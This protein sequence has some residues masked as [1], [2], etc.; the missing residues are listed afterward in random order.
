MPLYFIIATIVLM[1]PVYY[2][3]ISLG[4]EKLLETHWKKRDDLNQRNMLNPTKIEQVMGIICT[5]A[6]LAN[7]Y[8]KW[9]TL[10][11]IFMFNPCHVVCVSRKNLSPSL[12]ATRVLKRGSGPS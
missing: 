12:S 3:S 4:I 2:Y 1:S 8:Y 11:M 9:H 5:V 6:I 10:T 7:F